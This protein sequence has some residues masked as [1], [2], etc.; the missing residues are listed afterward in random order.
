VHVSVIAGMC[1]LNHYSL[2]LQAIVSAIEELNDGYITKDG[3][4]VLDFLEAI[5]AA[6][7]RQADLDALA[8]AE[9]KRALKVSL[10]HTL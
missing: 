10:L 6:E 3:K 7:K 4:L 5:H 9:E 2:E 1:L 8:F